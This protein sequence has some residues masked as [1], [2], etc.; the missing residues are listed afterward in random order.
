MFMT[1]EKGVPLPSQTPV[2]EPAG[3][4]MLRAPA[5]PA[6]IFLHI[7]AA[8]L[9][10]QEGREERT[11]SLSARLGEARRYSYETLKSLLSDPIIEQALTVASADIFEGVARIQRENTSPRRLERAYAGILR[12]LVRMSTRPTPFGLF[13]GVAVGTLGEKTLAHSGIP[14]IERIRT[15]PDMS[16]LLSIIEKLEEDRILLPQLH[17]LANRTVYLAGGRAII[18]YADIYGK[19]DQRSISLR[20]TSVVQ[21]IL[22]QACQPILYSDL[23][24]R[25]SATFPRASAQ[26]IDGLLHQL[27]DHHFL[28]SDLRPPLTDTD[29]TA[30]LV[31]RLQHVPEA[32]SVVTALQQ[33]TAKAGTIDRAG[34]GGSSSLIHA[35]VERQQQLLPAPSQKNQL[36]QI[37]AALR[38]ETPQLNRAI[39]EAVAEVAEILLRLGRSPQGAQNLREYYAA[40]IERYGMEAEVPLLELLSPETGLDAPPGYHEPPRTYPLPALSPV[41]MQKY[42]DV[43]CSLLTTAL[44]TGTSMIELTTSMMQQLTQW[45]PEVENPPPSSL[46]MYV[47][48]HAASREAIDRGEWLGVVAPACLSPGGRTFCRFF[49]ILGPESV[50]LLQTYAKREELLFPDKVFA[51]LSYLPTAGR[52]ANVAIRPALRSYEIVVNTSPSVPL[53]RGI[54]LDDLVVGV[55]KDRLYVRSLRL[56]K[57]VMVTQSHMLNYMQ[58][59]NVC[60]FLLEVS[61]A[62]CPGLSSFDWGAL[63]HAPFLPRVLHK[64]IVLSPAQW[65]VRQGTIE[66][67]GAGNEEERWFTGVQR[68][69]AQWRVPRYVYLTQFDH[70][71]LLD[72]QHPLMVDELGA[73][74][75]KVDE[76][77]LLC[78][79]EMLPDFDHLWLRDRNNTP[80]FSEVVVPLILQERARPQLASANA[81]GRQ[82]RAVTAVSRPQRVIGDSERRHLPGKEWTYLKLY[83]PFRQHDELISRPLREIIHQMT[84]QQLI[85]RWFYLRYA[86]PEPHLRVRFHAAQVQF[87]ADV[88]LQSL[89]WSQSLAHIGL[90]RR[91]CVDSYDQEIE[92]YGGPKAIDAIEKVF[93]ANSSAASTLVAAQYAR[94]IV[95]DPVVVA[96][97]SMD[98]FLKAWGGD[99]ARQLHHTLTE[100]AGKYA[101]SQEFR[102]QRRLL[103]EMLSPWDTNFDPAIMEQRE[104]VVLILAAQNGVLASVGAYIRELAAQG[105]LWQSEEHIVTS[106]IH[107]QMNRL[108]GINREQEQKAYAFWQQAFESIQRRPTKK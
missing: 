16:W 69:R 73:A 85:D 28:L 5:L 18:P 44:H 6:P 45:T 19:G 51:E 36:Y 97:F 78:L 42:D 12:Y 100:Q 77:G 63:K 24:E 94:Q 54:S 92:R 39:G 9:D 35:L 38:L 70:R 48:I 107:V 14:A 86:D 59:P 87:Q 8:A 34:V 33:V 55:Q 90:I 26:Q 31:K 89:A 76:G 99:V 102:P 25:V 57:E 15:R 67:S 13:S 65:N 60:R 21:Y 66:P 95:L 104:K 56:G 83:A 93:A 64:Q 32:A 84:E 43:L 10:G 61:S 71:L 37:D 1:V 88:L 58:A 41:Q 62:G 29:P 80:Y 49:D 40:F 30:Y 22:E 47:Q 4:Y 20:A 74:L 108:L 53:D 50:Q 98:Q 75:K 27:W 82:I 46:E 105:A 96:V 101:G 11:G 2:Y 52:G 106:L 7:T 17:V 68:W 91:V 103:C 72:L 23:R 79:Q 81:E 3:F